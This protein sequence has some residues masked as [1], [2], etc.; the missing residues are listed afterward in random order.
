MGVSWRQGTATE[1]FELYWRVAL[2]WLEAEALLSELVRAIPRAVL[3][4]LSLVGRP[5]K[6]SPWATGC[7]ERP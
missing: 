4:L 5:E 3:E 2:S 6:V 7:Y 1:G